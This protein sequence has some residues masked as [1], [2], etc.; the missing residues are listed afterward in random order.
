MRV[1]LKLRRP[2][3]A[4]MI[5]LLN[6]LSKIDSSKVSTERGT[7][8]PRQPRVPHTPRAPSPLPPCA[9]TGAA[10]RSHPRG[11][12]R[13]LHPS[14]RRCYTRRLRPQPPARAPC[15]PA[16]PPAL[17]PPSHHP[18]GAPHPPAPLPPFPSG[19]AVLPHT[20]SSSPRSGANGVSSYLGHRRRW[21]APRWP[22]R[23]P[24]GSR[25]TSVGDPWRCGGGT[26]GRDA[27]RS[28]REPLAAG[29]CPAL[30]D[31]HTPLGRVFGLCGKRSR[32][33]PSV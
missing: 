6:Y 32:K 3:G 12:P 4:K 20:P 14:R 9:T 24:R 11:C 13:F 10:S 8:E 33:K 5:Y 31:V 21:S 17:L 7:R 23:C 29:L 19:S 15:P 25:R 16:T 27:A 28:P 26:G 1:C 30:P 18:Q 2:G 22:S